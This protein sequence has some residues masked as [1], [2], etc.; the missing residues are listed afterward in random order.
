MLWY[1]T[2][3]G[4]A[5]GFLHKDFYLIKRGSGSTQNEYLRLYHRLTI[6]GWSVVLATLPALYTGSS[7]LQ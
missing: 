3:S 5:P 2:T 6:G 7:K 4:F 1:Q